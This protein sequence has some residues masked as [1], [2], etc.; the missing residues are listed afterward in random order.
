MSLENYI[1]SDFT[2]VSLTVL[3]GEVAY[4]EE[5]QMKIITLKKGFSIDIK[6]EKFHRIK[7]IG[8]YP[9]CYMYIYTNQTKQTLDIRRFVIR[10]QLILY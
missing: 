7:T 5:N 8:P 2:N 9:A 6:T 3:E 1:N 10:A 4:I